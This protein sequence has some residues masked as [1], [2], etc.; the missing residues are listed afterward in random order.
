MSTL[1]P[2]SGSSSFTL[3]LDLDTDGIAVGAS[4]PITAT[5]T[6]AGH[7]QTLDL[8]PIANAVL[9]VGPGRGG[10]A[11]PFNSPRQ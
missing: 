9:G 11:V 10:R 4:L 8:S 1:R 2:Q 6:S 7:S 3:N 5:L